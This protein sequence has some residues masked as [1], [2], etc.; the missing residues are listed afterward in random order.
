M[1]EMTNVQMSNVQGGGWGCFLSGVVTGVGIITLQ[2][3]LVVAG[4]VGGVATC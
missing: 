1:T 4:V 3:E 2:P